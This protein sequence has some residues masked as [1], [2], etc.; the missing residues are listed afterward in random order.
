M[1]SGYR[2]VAVNFL[3]PYEKGQERA[4]LALLPLSSY[5]FF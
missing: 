4:Y 3:D 2:V 5:S 1:P